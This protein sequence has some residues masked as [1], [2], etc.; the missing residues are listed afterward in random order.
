LF[1]LLRRAVVGGNVTGGVWALLLGS[2]TAIVQFFLGNLINPGGF[3]TSRWLFG[4]VDLISLSVLIPLFVYLLIV[5]LLI[6]LKRFSHDA[7]FAGFSLLWLI[8]VGGLRAL[9]WSAMSDPILLVMVP[10]LW[11]AIAAGIGFFI[12]LIITKF[13]WYILLFSIPCMLVLPFA[14]ATA[15]WAFFSHQML[16][17]YVLLAAANIPLICS[18]IFERR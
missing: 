1:Y 2:I 7:D 3:G 10:V 16:L 14:A 18:F 6:I 13:K 12:H 9:S 8:P 15:Y 5:I 11:T 4:F 17:G